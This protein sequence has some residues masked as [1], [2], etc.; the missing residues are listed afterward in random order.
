MGGRPFPSVQLLARPQFRAEAMMSSLQMLLTGIKGAPGRIAQRIIEELDVILGPEGA[1]Q[2][3]RALR[4]TRRTL[5]PDEANARIGILLQGN[6][7]F[8][9]AR[10]GSVEVEVT[11]NLRKLALLQDPER[12]EVRLSKVAWTRARHHQA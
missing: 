9:V 10:L 4:D 5:S 2:S 3:D 1:R 12:Q 7:P 6:R 11:K 8:M